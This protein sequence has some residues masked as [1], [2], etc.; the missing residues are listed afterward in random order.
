LNQEHK[1]SDE[2]LLKGIAK[3]DSRII[4]YLYKENLKLIRHLVISN[5]GNDDDARDI[6]QESLVV[7]YRKA[8]EKDFRLTSSLS[9][10]LY[11]IAKL[12]W[13][14][15][16]H[17]RKQHGVILDEF[18]DL[19]AKELELLDLIDRNEKLKLFREKFEELSNDCK[20]VLRMFLNNIPIREI[21][22]AMGY[23][24]DQHTK[25]RR[26]RCKKTLV[27]NIRKSSKYKELRN[28]K[29]KDDRDLPR[30]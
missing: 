25:N 27:M 22:K 5:N 13:L 2:E 17:I 29:N 9:T 26:F 18:L 4:E 23:S 19:T 8:K 24:S 6:F 10:Y 1:Y 12:M 20:K 7:L 28:E 21:T 30:W 16:L 15:E 14:K 3:G 11:S